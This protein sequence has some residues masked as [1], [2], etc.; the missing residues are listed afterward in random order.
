MATGLFWLNA[1]TAVLGGFLGWFLGDMDG[2]LYILTAFVA[3]DYI[4]GLMCAIHDRALSS[5][6]GWTDICKKVAIFLLVGVG[7]L[8]D[9]Y[10]LQNDHIIRTSIIFFY[11]SNE[12]ISLLENAVLLG[13]PVPETLRDMLS[14]FRDRDKPDNNLGTFEGLED[15]RE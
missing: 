13:L 3:A 6:V 2:I 14:W 12:G 1:I 4:T 8:V 9:T 15:K 5:K 11:L 10:V 7:H